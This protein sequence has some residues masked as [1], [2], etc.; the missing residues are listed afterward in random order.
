MRHALILL[1]LLTA[2]ACGGHSTAAPSAD[3]GEAQIKY[4]RCLR[5]NGLP[6]YPDDPRKL[7]SGGIA[8]PDRAVTACAKLR[9]PGRTIDPSDPK[10]R[11]HFLKL[12]RCMR[13]HGVDW[14]DPSP[15]DL[16]GPPPDLSGVPDK[17][18]VEAWLKVC[19]RP[20]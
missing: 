9:P 8:I 6:N 1:A 3:P 11:D 10:V 14:P 5:A 18:K 19:N 4:A 13:S 16:G 7:P 12:A 17:A 2:T 20:S 15:G